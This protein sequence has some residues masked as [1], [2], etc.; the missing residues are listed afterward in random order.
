MRY[1]LVFLFLSGCGFQ[2]STNCEYEQKATMLKTA[3]DCI[4][5]PQLG[6][7]KEY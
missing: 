2:W 4:E 3:K 1:L 5:Q 6:I 7:K